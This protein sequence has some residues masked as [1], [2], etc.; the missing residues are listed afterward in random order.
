V[1]IERGLV[2]D[3]QPARPLR[4][5]A[6]GRMSVVNVWDQGQD[7]GSGGCWQ[8]KVGGGRG[9]R[10]CNHAQIHVTLHKGGEKSWRNVEKEGAFCFPP[11]PHD[12]CS[13]WQSIWRR[14]GL[15]MNRLTHK[16][17]EA[18]QSTTPAKDDE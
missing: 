10:N 1:R 4:F 8:G 17:R 15:I 6:V 13:S 18:E 9:G 7:G 2:A 12:S 14:R 16:G 5:H 11:F 3:G